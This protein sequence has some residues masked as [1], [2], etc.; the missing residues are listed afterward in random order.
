MG[1]GSASLLGAG[2]LQV[3][4]I[5]LGAAV[6]V[7]TPLATKTGSPTVVEATILVF[8]RLKGLYG[9]GCCRWGSVSLG[10]WWRLELG[11]WGT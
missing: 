8:V 1:V 10:A 4:S 6:L 11:N 9:L 7:W 3:A 2:A 5:A